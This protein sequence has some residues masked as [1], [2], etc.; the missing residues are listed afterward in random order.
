MCILATDAAPSST[1]IYMVPVTIDG[2]AYTCMMYTNDLAVRT[3]VPGLMIVP[4]PNDSKASVFGLVDVTT[5]KAFREEVVTAFPRSQRYTN[6]LGLYGDGPDFVP[7]HEIGNYKISVVPDLAGLNTSIN[8]SRFSVPNDIG[9]RLGVLQ[10]RHMVPLHSGFVVAE[11]VRSVKDDGFGVVFPGHHAMFPTCH[12]GSSSAVHDFDVVCYGVV[13]HLPGSSMV[14]RDPA[15][16]DRLQSL[17]TPAAY[18]SHNGDPCVITRQPFGFVSALALQGPKTNGN[19]YGK[20]DPGGRGGFQV[21]SEVRPPVPVRETA[22]AGAAAYGHG[23]GLG[24]PMHGGPFLDALWGS[25][26]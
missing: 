15:T 9:T 19:V 22:T 8:W 18:W 1:R 4:F 14:S 5:M 6:T 11:A 24:R 20:H 25:I 26:P 7:V 10:D 3:G 17:F 13:I 23:H 21:P 2:M 16:L 12:E